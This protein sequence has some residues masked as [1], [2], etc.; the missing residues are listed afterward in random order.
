MRLANRDSIMDQPR[1]RCLTKGSDWERGT[2]RSG[3]NW[4][5]ARRGLFTVFADRVELGDWRIP[6]SEIERAIEYRIPYLFL[7]RFSVLEI[8][9]GGRVFQFGFNPWA[10]PAKHLPFAVERQEAKLGRSIY[11]VLLRLAILAY[12]GYLFWKR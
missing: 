8:E 4:V 12:L 1:Y 3:A 5:L 10:N 11:S 2:P 9:A 7:F 6:F